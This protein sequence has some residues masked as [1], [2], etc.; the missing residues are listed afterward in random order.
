MSAAPRRRSKTAQSESDEDE[1]SGTEPAFRSRSALAAAGE[2]IDLQGPAGIEGAGTGF[3]GLG[4]LPLRAPGSVG[5]ARGNVNLDAMLAALA[6]TTVDA[7]GTQGAAGPDEPGPL[8]GLFGDV[9]HDADSRPAPD[10]LTTAF[11]LALGMGLT[12]GPVL[13]DLMRLIPSI[14]PRRGIA[15]A[16]AA[17]FFRDPGLVSGHVP[18]GDGVRPRRPGVPTEPPTDSR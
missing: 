10:Y 12:A 7:N 9:D 18:T 1:E 11:V 4:P 8:L 6:V 14:A 3:T 15:P 5:A 16:G 13:P 17:R 2:S